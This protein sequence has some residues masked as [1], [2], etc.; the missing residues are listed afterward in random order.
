MRKLR[1]LFTVVSVIIC[2]VI[3]IIIDI[4]LR[5][6]DSSTTDVYVKWK[7]F[8]TVQSLS[9]NNEKYFAKSTF[10]TAELY[11]KFVDDVPLDFQRQILNGS[12]LSCYSGTEGIF[13]KKYKKILNIL[14]QYAHSHEEMT[15]RS[16]NTRTLIWWCPANHLCRGLADR[17]R[18]ITFSLYLAISSHRRL[19]LY[20]ESTFSE[21]FYFKPNLINWTDSSLDKLLHQRKYLQSSA[22]YY[23]VVMSHGKYPFLKSLSIQD[24]QNYLNIIAGQSEQHVVISTN[25]MPSEAVKRFPTINQSWLLDLFDLAEL[26][27][28]DLDDFTGVVFR[29]LF[30]IDNRL[31]EE[32]SKAK[33]A[34]N[35]KNGLL[36]TAIHIR[37]GFSGVLFNSE[38]NKKRFL[39]K[40]HQWKA[41]L[42]CAMLT[43]D[44]FVGNNSLIFLATDS[45][46]VK[47]MAI[48][49]Y[50]SR[51]KTLSNH[52]VHIDS[53]KGKR[54]FL[55]MEKEGIL[56]G[57]V[58]LILLAESHVLVRGRSGFSW[59]SGNLCRPLSNEHFID[60]TKCSK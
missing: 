2:F 22:P 15:K 37:T 1:R 4:S 32:V 57:L 6:K 45:N 24:W 26:S 12:P 25:L 11:Q 29:Y 42:E 7:Q 53:I 17:I 30:K 54:N 41:A 51:F 13:P 8:G 40:K 14:A 39:R 10:L 60:N 49:T 27:G 31:L 52:L 38:I 56:Y 33:K 34:L 58:D 35:L 43:A 5:N 16:T 3:Y 48:N 50:G 59:F 47:E 21:R 9:S 23:M 18:G 46:V 55:K 20:W 44:K 36:Y 28:H 19:V